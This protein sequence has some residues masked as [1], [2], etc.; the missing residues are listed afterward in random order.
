MCVCVIS[1]S[2][3][4]NDG[5]KLRESVGRSIHSNHGSILFTINQYLIFFRSFFSAQITAL[6][7]GREEDEE[8][9]TQ[10]EKKSFLGLKL[11][12]IL[13]KSGFGLRRARSD[14]VLK[15]SLFKNYP[16]HPLTHT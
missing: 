1:A 5:A 15:R 8:E 11:S 13:T 12:R 10:L 14:D 16:T 6:E 7:C 9:A 3:E 4:R 2:V